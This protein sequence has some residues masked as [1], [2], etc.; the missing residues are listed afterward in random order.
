M[1][2]RKL[3]V[4]LLVVGIASQM[5]GCIR[6]GNLPQ[7]GYDFNEGSDGWYEEYYERHHGDGDQQNTGREMLTLPSHTTGFWRKQRSYTLEWQFYNPVTKKVVVNSCSQ[8][9]LGQDRSAF[10]PVNDLDKDGLDDA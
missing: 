7:E 5:Q 9:A 2:P 3:M 1:S 6:S 4:G 8:A 10:D